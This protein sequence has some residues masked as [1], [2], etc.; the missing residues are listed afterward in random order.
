[1]VSSMGKARISACAASLFV[2][3]AACGGGG[4][5]GGGGLVPGPDPPQSDA[6]AARFLTQ[7]TFGPTVGEIERL[8]VIGYTA[9]LDEQFDLPPT[10]SRAV[11][12]DVKNSNDDSIEQGHRVGRWWKVAVQG[13]DQL[14][15]R[16]AFALS[17]IF[18]ISDQAGSLS[19]D[20]IG[21]AEYY[22]I[23]VRDAFGSYRS[24]LEDVT[25]S[26]QMGKYLSM[27]RN[28]K[29]DPAH[30]IR[31]D[32]NY[33]REIMQLFSVGLVQLNADGTPEL[34]QA[35]AQIPT[36]SQN[37][38]QELA[39]VFTG[40]NFAN[41][42]SWWWSPDDWRPMTAWESYHDTA[43]KTILGGHFI[44]GGQSAAQDLALALDVLAAH[45][46]VG[47]FLSRQLIQR[48][49]TSNPTPGYVAR[50]AAVFDD[51]GTGA[52]GN[53]KALVRALLMDDEARHG[54]ENL[55]TVFGKVREPLLAQ[56]A[57]WRAFDAHSSDG[58]YFD[59]WPEYDLAQAPLRSPSVF[60]FFSPSYSPSGAAAQAGLVA[61]ELQI[62]TDTTTATCANRM[63]DLTIAGW[64]GNN[65]SNDH[66]TLL[67]L[68]REK[69]LA[70]NA[71][72]LLDELNVLLLGGAMPLEMRDIIKADIEK[73]APT[74]TTQR[75]VEAL[76][77]IVTSPEFAVQK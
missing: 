73:Y 32:E 20:V 40:W 58:R 13:P 34:D 26:P 36:Y 5:G 59:W 16:V 71:D 27:L 69:A 2:A 11:L 41:A 61:P 17:E 63:W 53:L 72:A 51:D 55:P 50:V 4:S 6:Q 64:A 52:R 31:P 65:W 15:Q 60:N 62:V 67:F 42:Q 29:A 33:A 46:N 66:S 25:L 28:Q 12:Q 74:E 68:A 77:L 19:S 54:H 35:G 43:P 8:S 70:A 44:A 30:N 47:P 49:V 45:P 24:L 1:M 21:M 56:T 75:V 14:R 3:L 37:D 22:D 57:L 39:R 23:L 38:V 18:V 76:Y 7:S 9:W 48:L 10:L